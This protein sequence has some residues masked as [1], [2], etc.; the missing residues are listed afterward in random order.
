M[1]SM[2]SNSQWLLI[3]ESGETARGKTS[4]PYEVLPFIHVHVSHSVHVNSSK[5]YSVKRIELLIVSQIPRSHL[6]AV[7]YSGDQVRVVYL[8][9]FS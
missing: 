3:F 4:T 7:R 8:T 2:P 6:D 5:L 9:P 1:V